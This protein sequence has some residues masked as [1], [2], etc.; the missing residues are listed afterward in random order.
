MEVVKG[1]VRNTTA[2]QGREV[3]AMDGGDEH[4]FGGSHEFCRDLAQRG[5]KGAI[6][7][8]PPP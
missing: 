4:V 3:I 7:E 8:D 5:P 6:H 1:T 2:K